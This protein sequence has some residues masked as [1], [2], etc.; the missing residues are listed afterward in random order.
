MQHY[1]KK[2]LSYSMV[3]SLGL[4]FVAGL[5]G[6]DSGTPTNNANTTNNAIADAAGQGLFMV[7]QQT[8]A[9]PDTYELKEKYPSSEGT[10]AILKGLDGSEKILN[11]EELKKIAEAEAK[12]FEE[13]SSQLSQPT[14]QNQG[15]SLGE[16]I[17]ASAAG[18]LIG[19]M[20]ANKL[21][22]NSNYQQHQQ[23]QNQRAQSTMSSTRNP[24]QTNNTSQNKSQPRSG[25]FGGNQGNPSNSSKSGGSSFG[26]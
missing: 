19:G 22:S 16:T 20:I 17:L 1:I 24:A 11:E 21:M 4:T 23:Q 2:I 3:G 9:N 18:A 26:G 6:C 8:G 14:A 7:I 12:R 5:Q 10:R 25:F 15:L 13:G